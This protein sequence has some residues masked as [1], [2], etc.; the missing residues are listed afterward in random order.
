MSYGHNRDRTGVSASV[1]MWVAQKSRSDRDRR[2]RDP[3]NRV[4]SREV[5][6]NV[7]RYI[8]G[9]TRKSYLLGH[10]LSLLFKKHYIC[11]DLST[12]KVQHYENREFYR[13]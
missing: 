4:I 7:F 11:T 3:P 5:W 10:P 13:T 6:R 9:E 12:S 2:E 8:R 1:T